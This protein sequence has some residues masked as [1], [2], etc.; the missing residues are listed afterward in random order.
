MAS[1][2]FSCRLVWD[3]AR[4]KYG[5]A[6]ELKL[7]TLSIAENGF[8]PD[9]LLRVSKPNW[10]KNRNENHVSRRLGP[11]RCEACRCFPWLYARS[12]RRDFFQTEFLNDGSQRSSSRSRLSEERLQNDYVH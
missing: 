12:A 5:F 9:C 11:T 7:S 1:S 3:F 6:V 8:C 10:R 4:S 2:I